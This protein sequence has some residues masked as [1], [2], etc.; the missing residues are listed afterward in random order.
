M[1]AKKTCPACNKQIPEAATEC[2]QCKKQLETL[3]WEIER[4]SNERVS[5]SGPGGVESLREK[6]ISGELKLRDR[7]RQYTK[8]L[9]RVEAS[10]EHFGVKK[11]KEWKTLRDYANA[12]FSL[13][14]LYAP[15]QACAKRGAMI[16]G[17]VVGLLVAIAWNTSGLLAVGANPAA[18]V[19]LA[20]GML[21]LFPTVI[22]LII[23]SL[24]VSAIYRIPAT[25]M[26]FRTLIAA[27]LGLLVGLAVGWTVGY[28][29]GAL[30]GL[31]VKKV[32]E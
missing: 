11:E 31:R 12:E 28:A 16:T 32:L 27:I 15:V 14:V 13:Q 21:L 23:G 19:V 26:G 4:E 30:C 25:G 10:E 1:A 5:F 3:C 29:I 7:C 17:I 22:G 2:P 24:V 20:I 18:A 8:V 6:L 9:E